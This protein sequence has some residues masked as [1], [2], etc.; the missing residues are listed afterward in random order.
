MYRYRTSII[1]SITNESNDLILTT[2][3]NQQIRFIGN[4]KLKLKEFLLYSYGIKSNEI[5][6]NNF[7]KEFNFSLPFIFKVDINYPINDIVFFGAFSNK[8]EVNKKPMFGKMSNNLLE[9]SKTKNGKFM[10]IKPPE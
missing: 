10:K 2:M 1:S 5:E 4:N 8:K 9:N 3:S 7:K 6:N